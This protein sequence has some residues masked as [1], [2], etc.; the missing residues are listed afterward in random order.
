MNI[1]VM[2]QIIIVL[3]YIMLSL[4]QGK[5]RLCLIGVL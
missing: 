4:L 5:K 2:Y 3:E 1:A